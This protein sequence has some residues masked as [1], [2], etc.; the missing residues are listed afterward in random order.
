MSI[1]LTKQIVDTWKLLRDKLDCCTVVVTAG[2]AMYMHDLRQ[3]FNGINIDVTNVGWDKIK[4]LAYENSAGIQ[5]VDA[6]K[7]FPDEPLLEKVTIH[8][9]EPDLVFVSGPGKIWM[10][11]TASL[12]LL[13]RRLNRPKDQGWIKA[14]ETNLGIN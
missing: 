11:D 14:L 9:M 6:I 10:Y 1:E 5:T 8:R 2:A 4:H 12:L 3:S 13:Y 7:L